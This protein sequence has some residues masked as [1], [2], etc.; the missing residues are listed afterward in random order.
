[1][2]LSGPLLSPSSAWKF[3]MPRGLSLQLCLPGPVVLVAAFP[4]PRGELSPGQAEAATAALCCC[5]F[6]AAVL[7]LSC[8]HI[9]KMIATSM[10][11][12]F[13]LL[14]SLFVFPWKSLKSLETIA[15]CQ[16]QIMQRHFYVLKL[17]SSLSL[18]FLR[19]TEYQFFFTICNLLVKSLD[20]VLFISRHWK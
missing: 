3:E 2:P 18:Y 12:S 7:V 19:Y 10:S 9:L 5:C 1:M 4:W 8:L 16:L 13:L 6:C 17:V 11:E 15:C 20:K 14:L